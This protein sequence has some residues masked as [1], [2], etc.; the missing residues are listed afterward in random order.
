MNFFMPS[1][2]QNFLLPFPHI[3]PPYI[4]TSPLIEKFHS[5]YA[6]LEE[7]L[8]NDPTLLAC[9]SMFERTTDSF[10]TKVVNVKQNERLCGA[11]YVSLP[12]FSYLCLLG[13]IS[14]QSTTKLSI[15]QDKYLKNFAFWL[16]MIIKHLH[17]IKKYDS[18]TTKWY[19]FRLQKTV[20]QFVQKFFKHR[21]TKMKNQSDV[22][23]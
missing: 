5:S 23:N 3:L 22:Q 9:T 10:F 14:L 17:L 21:R 16:I 2:F 8:V 4:L 20:F 19:I 6:L 13:S 7:F 12:N 1:I 11:V 18:A 15:L